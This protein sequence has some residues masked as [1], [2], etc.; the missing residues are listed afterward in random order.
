MEEK[1]LVHKKVESA[2]DFC[3]FINEKGIKKEDILHI[4]YI[5]GIY[6]IFYWK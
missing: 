6:T 1:K 5:N 2:V 4:Q 3:T